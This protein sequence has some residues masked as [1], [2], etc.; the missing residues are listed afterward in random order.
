MGGRG[1]ERCGGQAGFVPSKWN[2][3]TLCTGLRATSEPAG[4]GVLS[5]A[6]KPCCFSSFSLS[7]KPSSSLS[8]SVH[9]AMPAAPRGWRGA[10]VGSGGRQELGAGCTWGGWRLTVL[11]TVGSRSHAMAWVGRDPKAHLLPTPH[12][13]HLMAQ[14]PDGFLIQG[15]ALLNEAGVCRTSV[16]CEEMSFPAVLCRKLDGQPCMD[17][18]GVLHT[19]HLSVHRYPFLVCSGCRVR[20]EGDAPH[21]RDAILRCALRQCCNSLAC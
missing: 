18:P 4:L 6:A 14:L 3:S 9:Q 17:G 21:L 12:S 7:T 10:V 20:L 8:P 15:T 13:R 19:Q 5:V 16:L 2:K 11:L 1:E